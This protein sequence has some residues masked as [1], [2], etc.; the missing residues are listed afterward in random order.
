MFGI[1]KKREAE[2]KAIREMKEAEAQQ[3]E[4]ILYGF[5]FLCGIIIGMAIQDAGYRKAN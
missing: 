5:V 3:E 1:N 2:E 4:M